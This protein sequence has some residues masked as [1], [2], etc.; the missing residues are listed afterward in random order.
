MAKTTSEIGIEARPYK[1]SWIDRFTDW[2]EKLPVR[3]WI[4]YVLLLIQVVFLWLDGGLQFD[5]LLPVII[6]NALL[7]PYLLALIHLLDN[8]AITALN[9]MKPALSIDEP[10]FDDFQYKLSTMPARATFIIGL[11]LMVSLVLSELVWIVPDRYA[12]LDALPIFTIIYQI[13]D[14]IVHQI[15]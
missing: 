1:P 6:F 3:K 14:K 12:A 5:V 11:T 2:V 13:I 15:P 8:Q 9:S 4:F 10:E 7:I